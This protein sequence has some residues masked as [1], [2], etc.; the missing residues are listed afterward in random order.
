MRHL[1]EKRSRPSK[2]ADVE[3]TR[4]QPEAAIADMRRRAMRL[5][6]YGAPAPA[7]AAYCPAPA[8]THGS[9]DPGLLLV[10]VALGGL[11]RRAQGGFR[12][13]HLAVN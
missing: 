2:A 6:L 5:W 12:L 8:R 9:G 1:F 7:V 4:P 13:Q 11:G 10:Q 3:G